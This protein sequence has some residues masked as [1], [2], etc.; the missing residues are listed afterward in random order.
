MI[1]TDKELMTA[2]LATEAGRLFCGDLM[3]VTG[4]FAPMERTDTNAVMMLEGQ[5]SVGVRVF[6]AVV[7]AGGDPVALMKEY[8]VW[9]KQQLQ[10]QDK[11]QEEQ[12][13]G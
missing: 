6:T 10:K 3:R 2:L 5:R 9:F 4:V 13:N 8:A 7:N 11:K 1:Q 12:V